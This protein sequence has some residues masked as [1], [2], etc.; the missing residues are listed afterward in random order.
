M[1][2]FHFSSPKQFLKLSYKI[3]DFENQKS[4][5]HKLLVTQAKLISK[6]LLFCKLEFSLLWN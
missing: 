1:C 5:T 6:T 3:V 4:K 2:F